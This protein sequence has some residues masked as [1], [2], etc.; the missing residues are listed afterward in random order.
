M[1]HY[2]VSFLKNLP[3]CNGHMFRC[4]Q[5]VI[6]VDAA[7]QAEAIATAKAMFARRS[8]D[9]RLHADTVEI[10]ESTPLAVDAPPPRRERSAPRPRTH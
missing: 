4:T 7:T 8:G 2:N 1:P 9:W 10:V 6:A 5:D 3:S